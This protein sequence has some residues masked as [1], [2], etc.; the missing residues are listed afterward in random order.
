MGDTAFCTYESINAETRLCVNS[1]SMYR[2]TNWPAF[3]AQNVLV[4]ND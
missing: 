3:T 2:D 1:V 4:S